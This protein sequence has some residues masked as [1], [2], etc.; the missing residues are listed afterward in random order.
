MSDETQPP[1]TPAEESDQVAARRETLARLR[2]AGH[3]PFL[4]TRFDRTHEA[5]ALQRDFDALENQPV[6]V[7]GRLLALRRHGK[8]TFA[9][10]RDG[11]GRVQLLFRTN[12]LG[13][14]AYAA[15]RPTSIWATW[16]A[17]Q[18]P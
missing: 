11:S 13:E 9:D 15:P 10:L 16:S 7:A 12:T 5:A 6:R 2:E 18:D 4:A 14:E 17:R 3:D 1:L 8:A